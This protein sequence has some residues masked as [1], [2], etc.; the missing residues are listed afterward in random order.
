MD[1]CRVDFTVAEWE[2]EHAEQHKQHCRTL[3]PFYS[4][5]YISRLFTAESE[6]EPNE[7]Q[8][9]FGNV[10]FKSLKTKL[11]FHTWKSSFSFPLS[12][13]RDVSNAL[14]C[15]FRRCLSVV[16]RVRFRFREV[17]VGDFKILKQLQFPFSKPCLLARKTTQKIIQFREL[18]SRSK[19][20]AQTLILVECFLALT[21]E[22]CFQM[23]FLAH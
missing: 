10:K 23:A 21:L 16:F 12:I 3:S 6:T 5:W 4:A 2:R 9:S 14:H 17:A 19:V 22:Y 11:L 7:G 18:Y 8:S 15:S 13:S 20:D 1:S